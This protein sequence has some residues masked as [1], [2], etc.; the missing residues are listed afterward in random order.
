MNIQDMIKVMQQFEAGKQIQI[1]TFVGWED[2][3]GTP[4][5]DWNR[6]RYRCKPN[7][8]QELFEHMESQEI[9][10]TTIKFICVEHN[11]TGDKKIL[12]DTHIREALKEYMNIG[13]VCTFS[14][15]PMNYHSE[16]CIAEINKSE[17]AK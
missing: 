5:W 15:V 6:N 13:N 16:Q 14:L 3:E 4:D 1:Q 2:V 8:Y 11:D 9:S 12:F 17:Y 7:K 10:K